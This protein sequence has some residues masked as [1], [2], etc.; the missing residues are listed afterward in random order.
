MKKSKAKRKAKKKTHSKLY[1]KALHRLLFASTIS[2]LAFMIL[3]ALF[4]FV[5]HGSMNHIYLGSISLNGT[6]SQAR[7]EQKISGAASQY[8]IT[9]Q[10]PDATTK[11]FP[12]SSTGLDI[13]VKA[14]AQSAKQFMRQAVPERLRWWDPVYLPLE[15]KANTAYLKN[16]I[17][18]DA[19]QVTL[20]PED[21]A[22]AQD[23]GSIVITPSKQGKANEIGNAYTAVFNAVAALQT[24][25]LVLK[26]AV[27]QPAITTADLKAS[28]DKVNKI[29]SQE[30]KFNID[31]H[32]IAASKSDI[33][34]WIELSPVNK[35]KTVDVSV[36]SGKVLN[37]INKVARQYIQP[38]RSRLVT[39]TDSGQVVLDPGANGLDVV[40]KNQTAADTAKKLLDNKGL[41][42]D[43]SVKYAAAQTIET[44]A[45]DK[46]L[47]ADVSTKR[48]YAYEGTTL[49]KS[50]LISAGAPKTPTVIGKYAIYA[51]YKSQD[52]TGANADGS[53]YFQ[54]DVPYINYFYKD[55]AVHGNYWRPASYFGNINS[56]HGCIGINVQDSAW[57]YNWA[58]IGTPV[59]VHS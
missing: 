7:I 8:K 2:L 4:Y 21:A 33:A 25:P 59:I 3:T 52:M 39:A 19:T 17:N 29:L 57:I 49:V 32:E 43:L 10:Y 27:L 56:S 24:A 9:L 1:V 28:Q 40:N 30:V 34:G 31:G 35:Q 23:S 5:A 55:Y 50:F 47:V 38:P 51:K 45:Y 41:K 12:L 22:L 26:P 16:F 58:P 44:E 42:V 14:S 13:D 11:T 46:W 53:R 36:D 20:T 37:Y 54:P 6:D 15:V 18:Q 48:M